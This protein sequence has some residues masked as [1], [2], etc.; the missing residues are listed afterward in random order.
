M[1]GVGVRESTGFIGAKEAGLADWAQVHWA[2]ESFPFSVQ[3]LIRSDPDRPISTL[4]NSILEES[5][6]ISISQF[7]GQSPGESP[8]AV[9]DHDL[10]VVE[11]T[12][13][14]SAGTRLLSW[15]SSMDAVGPL[16]FLAA[17]VGI[18]AVSVAYDWPIPGWMAPLVVAA[19]G[20]GCIVAYDSRWRLTQVARVAW[21]TKSNLEAVAESLDNDV[22]Q[23]TL[24]LATAKSHNA[25]IRFHGVR[26]L[27]GLGAIPEGESGVQ[28][29][30]E[31][32]RA[33]SIGS[34]TPKR[35]A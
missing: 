22:A 20:F 3:L 17:A 31:R 12:R 15:L 29:L 34:G 26:R 2:S 8:V 9:D 6:F 24:S 32:F 16:F 4:L 27:D 23:V 25:R 14:L 10:I 19:M 28:D 13:D 33:I 1:V 5:G 11:R 30:I 18:L 35:G 7:S 21:S